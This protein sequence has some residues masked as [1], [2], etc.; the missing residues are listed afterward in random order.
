MTSRMIK[1]RSSRN[2]TSRKKAKRTMYS[3]TMT[4]PVPLLKSFVGSKDTLSQLLAGYKAQLD[5][6]LSDKQD[7]ILTVTMKHRNHLDVVMGRLVDR[8]NKLATI[9]NNLI[10]VQ[11]T[12]DTN[13]D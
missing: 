1:A 8:Y 13:K 11:T 12:I 5:F 3:E 10:A 2:N 6:S 4:M 7:I 9:A